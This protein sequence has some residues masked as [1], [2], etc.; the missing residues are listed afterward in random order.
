[1]TE[2][3]EQRRI[4]RVRIVQFML[5]MLA[6]TAMYKGVRWLTNIKRR[7]QRGLLTMSNT[8]HPVSSRDLESIFKQTVG[9]PDV[10]TN[11]I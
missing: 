2:E 10:P 1:M 9:T 3:E 7:T 6:L 5:S 11:T 8:R 4:R